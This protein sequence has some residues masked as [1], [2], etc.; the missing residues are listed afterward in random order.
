MSN[1]LEN[2]LRL[3]GNRAHTLVA[4]VVPYINSSKVMGE[5]GGD[6]YI[7]KSANVT[8]VSADNLVAV[9]PTTSTP[10]NLN[11]SVVDFKPQS[12]VTDRFDHAWLRISLTNNDANPCTIVPSPF[13]LNY[14]QIYGSNGNALLFQQYGYEIWNEIASFSNTLEWNQLGI[15]VGS[16][17][18]Y[19]TAGVTLASGASTVLY[20]PLFSVFASSRFFLEG[21][22]DYLLIRFTFNPSAQNLI[23]GVTPTVTQMQLLLRGAYDT[24]KVRE[25]KMRM[26]KT[27]PLDFP[28]MGCQRSQ[29][30]QTIAASSSY[31]IQLQGITGL[32]NCAWIFALPLPTTASNAGSYANIFSS[33]DIQNNNGDSII[34]YYQRSCFAA[35]FRDDNQLSTLEYWDNTFSLNKNII[36]V[37]FS[38]DPTADWRSGSSH[39]LQCWDGF[40]ILAFNTSASA[41]PG[42]YNIIVACKTAQTIKCR[43]GILSTNQN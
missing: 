36:F 4:D 9:Q 11:G 34:G 23:S 22:N 24:K 28:L 43:R 37:S 19:S 31:K 27:M 38:R 30:T 29:F 15:L 8:E 17:N 20:I 33:Y 41:T 21:L 35:D 12:G 13:L 14:W 2:A 1:F 16:N 40:N 25:L 18:T 42:I 5:E 26:Y 10:P 32:I 3:Y 7:H 39:G 6:V